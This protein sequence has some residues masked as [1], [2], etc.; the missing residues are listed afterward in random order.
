MEMYCSS[1][2]ASDLHDQIPNYIMTFSLSHVLFI[3]GPKKPKKNP[4][5]NCGVPNIVILM[6]VPIS[7]L[8]IMM[9]NMVAVFYLLRA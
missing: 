9:A 4:Q 5:G 2:L 8:W 7:A 1:P 3:S 6:I